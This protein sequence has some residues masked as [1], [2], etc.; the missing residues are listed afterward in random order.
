MG[1]I[2]FFFTQTAAISPFIREANARPVYGTTESRAC[3]L[4]RGRHLRHTYVNPSGSLDQ[5]E[6]RAKMFCTGAAIPA[7]SLVVCDGQQFTV[8]DCEVKNGFSDNHLE[9]YLE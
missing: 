7:R 2:E 4:E 6:A 9:V 3:R 5:I 1:L 8:I